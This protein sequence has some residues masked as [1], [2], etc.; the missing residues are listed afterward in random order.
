MALSPM[1]RLWFPGL[2]F[3][4]CAL[5]V[6]EDTVVIRTFAGVESIG[7]YTDTG[8]SVWLLL[9]GLKQSVQS[10]G[11][12]FLAT[13]RALEECKPQR[14]GRRQPQGRHRELESRA[15]AALPAGVQI[16]WMT[17]HQSDKD[18]DEG[19]VARVDLQ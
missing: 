10:S 17:A 15:L 1:N 8:E 3:T 5:M 11:V 18:A 14:T 12:K 6:L 16:V 9:P 2:D 7:Y 4:L 19:R 13:V